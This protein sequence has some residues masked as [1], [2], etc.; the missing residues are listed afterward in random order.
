MNPMSF[1]TSLEEAQKIS[2][3]LERRDPDSPVGSPC[4]NAKIREY[5]MAE[6]G[7][8]RRD[9]VF[10]R[11]ALIDGVKF[12]LRGYSD[13]GKTHYVDVSTDGR[14]SVIAMGSGDGLTP[15]QYL[16]LRYARGGVRGVAVFLIEQR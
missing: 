2:P 4:D 11:T 8:G 6:V 10:G 1:P 14:E 12:W 15:E 7:P 9:L 16:A 5:L 13:D 3:Q